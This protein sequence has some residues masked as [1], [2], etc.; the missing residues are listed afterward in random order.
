MFAGAKLFNSDISLWNPR[1]A[2]RMI[3]MFQ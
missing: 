1:K 2:A 3:A